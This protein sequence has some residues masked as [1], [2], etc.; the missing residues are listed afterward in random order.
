[1]RLFQT[2]EVEEALRF[3]AA[4]GQALHLHHVVFPESP[5]RF[6]RAVERGE[7]IAHLFDLDRAR[8]I[9]T[10]MHLGVASIYVDKEGSLR[11]HIDLEGGSLRVAIRWAEGDGKC[12]R[13]ESNQ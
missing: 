8:L 2:M 3:A 7:P 12:T 1:M 10:A 6:R 9:E 4:G 13:L 11:Q 5:P